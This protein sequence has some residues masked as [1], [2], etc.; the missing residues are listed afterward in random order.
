MGHNTGCI[1]FLHLH[2]RESF[3]VLLAIL[4]KRKKVTFHEDTF[5]EPKR[6]KLDPI[7]ET[8]DGDNATDKIPKVK[9]VPRAKEIQPNLSQA[10]TDALSVL[11][12]TSI[13][14]HTPPN[15]PPN[16]LP[17][18]IT[19]T[20]DE[21]DCPCTEDTEERLLWKMK[22]PEICTEQYRETTF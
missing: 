1:E 18:L 7:V 11:A 4:K 20:V 9:E 3:E 22:N 17:D 16:S 14:I 12:D 10:T 13:A 19:E 5:V 8:G 15:N 21:A 2:E 6:A